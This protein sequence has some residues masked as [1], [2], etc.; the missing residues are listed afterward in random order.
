MN[1]ATVECTTCGNSKEPSSAKTSCVSKCSLNQANFMYND[2]FC[3]CGTGRHELDNDACNIYFFVTEVM[4]VFDPVLFNVLFY[5][6]LSTDII[7]AKL[8]VEHCF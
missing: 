4:F 2:T 7:L 8:Y 6:L 3:F 1:G 5:V